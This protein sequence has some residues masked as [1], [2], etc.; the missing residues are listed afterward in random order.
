MIDTTY[1]SNHFLIAM[2]SLRD[3]NFAQTVTYIC[4]H[5]RDGALGLVI[6]RPTELT[7]G[8]LMEHMGEKATSKDR[9]SQIVH[10]G[11]P[12]QQDRGFV[13][14]SPLGQWESS[15]AITEVLGLTTSRDILISIA[16]DRGP[17]KSLIALGYAGWG[18]GQLEREIAENAWLAGPVEQEIL[19]DLPSEKRW[20]AAAASLG[21]DLRLLSGE[22]GHA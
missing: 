1:L 5:N 13:L 12:V 16:E 18:A 2:P 8:E 4:E 21:V 9:A 10:F 11:G 17:R 6:N 7:L 15:L 19:F 20:A 22:A 3:P 14:H